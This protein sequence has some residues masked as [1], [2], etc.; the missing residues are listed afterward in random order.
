MVDEPR[1]VL[2]AAGERDATVG[3]PTRAERPARSSASQDIFEDIDL[4]TIY[5]DPTAE[6]QTIR[7]RL[8]APW[9]RVE[10]ERKSRNWKLRGRVGG[11]KRWYLDPAEVGAE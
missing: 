8:A 4:A 7:D 2:S 10:A 9:N 5:G 11:G 1:R 6:R 3:L